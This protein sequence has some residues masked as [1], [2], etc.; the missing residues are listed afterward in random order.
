MMT[1]TELLRNVWMGLATLG[2]VVVLY[3]IIRPA[4]RV[5]PT[6]RDLSVAP[7]MA[8]VL[9]SKELEVAAGSA[10][11]RHLEKQFVKT[12]KVS[13]PL[14][15]VTASV[16]AHSHKGPGKA[17][18]R[19]QF[20]NADV[21]S[22]YAD[23]RRFQ[24]DV[25]YAGKQL[26]KT[27]ELGKAQ[28]AR[29]T[30]VYERLKKLVE[31]TGTEAKKDLSAAHADL[32]QAE[33]QTRKDEFD[34]ESTQNTALRNQAQ[35][36]RALAQ[37]G[38]DPRALD[39]EDSVAIVVA[40]VPEVQIRGV[41]EGQSCIAR[42]YGLPDATFPG[43][44]TR[45]VATLSTDRRTLRVLFH[46]DDPDDK[47]KPGMFA[48]VGIGTDS[49]DAMLVPEDGTVHVGRKDYVLA[50]AKEGPWRV[51]DVDLG[52]HR[53]PMIEARSGIAVGEEVIGRGAILL[54]PFIIQA[55]E[56]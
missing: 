39:Q 29:Y 9:D 6:E 31:E 44:I 47:L 22:A 23:W 42:F 38:I 21:S 11:E 25:D 49:R 34:A 27:R 43:K 56:K 36:I 48:D 18:D 55:L 30:E 40:Q 3:F 4:A 15:T 20:Q 2:V 16:A 35:A 45:I 52:E 54:K 33:I 26:E 5:T 32:I 1:R 24:N 46:L 7:P 13:I 8:R 28:L 14:L 50:R 10:L 12:E 19:W 51:Q 41:K 17:E 37:A 53:G